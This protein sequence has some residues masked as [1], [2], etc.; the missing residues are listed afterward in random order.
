MG[1]KSNLT[2]EMEYKAAVKAFDDSMRPRRTYLPG[3]DEG[4]TQ[5]SGREMD[6]LEKLVLLD[7]VMN[8]HGE[9]IHARCNR[10]PNGWRDY[11]MVARVLSKLVDSLLETCTVRTLE[12]LQA[13]CKNCEVSIKPRTIAK[14]DHCLVIHESELMQL[15]DKACSAECAICFKSGAEIKAC[16]LRKTL[17][18]IAPLDDPSR[19]DQ[20]GYA[21]ATMEDEK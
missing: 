6:V 14:E 8:K 20:C 13:M 4:R 19:M 17:M 18:E 5:A 10:I 1:K 15:I 3:A 2:R 11:R 7:A 16:K 21:M 12:R 9:I